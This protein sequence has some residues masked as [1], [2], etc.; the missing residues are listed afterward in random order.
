MTNFKF[1]SK[2][3]RFEKFPTRSMVLKNAIEESISI[4]EPIKGFETSPLYVDLT[5]LKIGLVCLK[6]TENG[7]YFFLVKSSNTH[8]WCGYC[9][10]YFH[11]LRFVNEI[12]DELDFVNEW[13]E[14]WLLIEFKYIS[15]TYDKKAPKYIMND[16]HY[17]SACCGGTLNFLSENFL[18]KIDCT[19]PIRVLV[20]MLR[21]NYNSEIYFGQ[22][23][24]FFENYPNAKLLYKYLA[25]LDWAKIL[26]GLN[27]EN[28]EYWN[29]FDVTYENVGIE[30]II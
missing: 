5:V 12:S 6:R 21:K 9:N 28:F 23:N 15:I 25:K 18:H 24:D 27:P 2:L 16:F 22:M 10:E 30:E 20:K 29:F 1:N 19:K 14:P 3:N 4:D 13:C 11:V 26:E 7:N 17:F 8:T